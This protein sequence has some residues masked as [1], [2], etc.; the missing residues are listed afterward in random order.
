MKSSKPDWF[1]RFMAF[2][3]IGLAATSLYF[4]FLS[5]EHSFRANIRNAS[6]M[7]DTTYFEVVLINDGDYN[8]IIK[9]GGFVFVPTKS[10]IRHIEHTYLIKNTEIEKGNRKMVKLKY[11]TYSKRNI[12]ELGLSGTDSC[13]I[14]IYFYLVTIDD[15]GREYVCETKIGFIDNDFKYYDNTPILLDL[16][17][18]DKTQRIDDK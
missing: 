13:S 14:N 12:W 3:G 11:Q 16:I 2:I 8:E 6:V 10:N 18:P 9:R 5:N 15:K 7:P 17:S 1:G 4:Q